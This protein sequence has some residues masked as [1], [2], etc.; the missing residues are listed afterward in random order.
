MIILFALG[1]GVGYGGDRL[2][3][4]DQ[5][6]LVQRDL[7][8]DTRF[9]LGGRAVR[10]PTPEPS[11]MIK[12]DGGYM[13]FLYPAKARK[14]P[15]KKAT[16]KILERADF[17]ITSPRLSI[18]AVASEATERLVGEVSGVMARRSQP[19]KY[20]EDQ[21]MVG[22]EKNP[23]F[24]TLDGREKVVFVIYNGRLYTL[25]V[26]GPDPAEVKAMWQKI[27][28]TFHFI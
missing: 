1:F 5:M 23:V 17:E 26:Y 8:S 27:I 24:T 2:R 10:E 7:Q 18:V 15:L 12:Y 9:V 11:G 21:V 6:P 28:P 4:Y 25:S 3:Q 20:K 19:D 22:V 16:D 13:T 14:Y